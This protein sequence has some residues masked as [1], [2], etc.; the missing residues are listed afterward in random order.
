MEVDFVIYGTNGIWAI[1][2]KNSDRPSAHDFKGLR[3]FK[4]DYPEA[5]C[6]LLYRGKDRFKRDD[7]LCMPCEKFLKDLK[8]NLEFL[9]L[10]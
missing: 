7:I 4:T 10:D 1:E 6:L 9:V 2:V 8:P 5:N 3:A